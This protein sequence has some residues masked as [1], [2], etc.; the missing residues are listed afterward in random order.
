MKKQS[1]LGFALLSLFF[2]MS[3]C[4]KSDS[5]TVSQSSNPTLYARLG[6][7]TKV[8]DPI[9]AGMLIEKGRLSY[10]S[11]V[12][13]TITLIVKDIT[14]NASGNF[15][16][17]FAPLLAEVGQGNTTNLAELSTNLTDF[18]S[19]NTGGSATNMY[20]GMSMQAAHNPATNMRMG[21]KATSADYDKFIGYVGL[22]ATKN[23]VTDQTIITDV[24]AVLES[25]RTQIVQN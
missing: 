9:H 8:A 7:T 22:A 25:L 1:V 5:N 4:S 6:G 24:V 19:A 13:T 14:I 2:T 15:S 12:D 3:S 16:Q 10:R 23:G 18:F 21:K 20:N 17:H 11:V